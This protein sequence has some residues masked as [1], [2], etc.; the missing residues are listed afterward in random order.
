MD[1]FGPLPTSKYGN[2]RVVV[3]I[4][5]YSK[6]V[7]AAAVPDKASETIRKF[8]RERIIFVMGRPLEII[9]D[10]GAEFYGDMKVECDRQGIKVTH[11]A[12]YHPQTQGLVEKA[13]DTLQ[14]G[15]TAA[16]QGRD[17][18]EWEEL[19][20]ECVAGMNMA[21]Q[22]TTG[23]SPFFLM[24]GVHPRLPIGTS[25][26]RLQDDIEEKEELEGAEMRCKRIDEQAERNRTLNQTHDKVLANV[27]RAQDRQISEYA[28]RR[29]TA[30]ALPEIGALV[31]I[32]LS[33]K[34]NDER[35]NKRQKLEGP[36]W[37]GPLKLVAY[38]EDMSRGIVESAATS[39]IKARRWSEDWADIA[40]KKMMDA[41]QNPD[42]AEQ[43][44]RVGSRH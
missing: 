8:L 36:Q 26:K 31:W 20:P 13:V 3:Y 15:L 37:H 2:V 17:R 11:G 5:Y 12:S 34:G 28:T 44:D 30:T 6:Y 19:L 1:M 33:R 14:K 25:G 9:C 22:R 4:D 21:R 38:S 42:S 7:T 43:K 27:S 24:H 35:E 41:T 23:F 40:T 10:R 32:R 18:A 39:E 16:I 29:K